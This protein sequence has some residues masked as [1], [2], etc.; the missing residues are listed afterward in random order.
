MDRIAIIG[1]GYIG[2]SIGY[3]LRL[4]HS[5][6]YRVVGFDYDSN[7]QRQ[8]DKTGALDESNWALGDTVR[9]ADI[10]VIATPSAAAKELFA[11]M[12]GDLKPGAIVTDTT[13]TA[14]TITGWAEE[15]L[16]KSVGFVAGHP[17]ISGVGIEEASGAAFDGA[18]WALAPTA[19][20]PQDAVRRTIRLVED[21]GAK[22]FFISVEEHDSYIAA[23]TNLPIIVSNAMMLAAARSP[24][25]REIGKFATDQFGEV[26]SA[27]RLNPATNIGSLTGNAEMTIHWIEQMIIELADFRAMLEDE[28]RDDPDGPL[29]ETLNNAWEARLRWENGIEPGDIQRPE[30][31]TSGD[32]MLGVLVGYKVAERLKGVRDRTEQQ[33][34]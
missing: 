27:S 10:I 11:D 26:S 16:P 25:W 33:N 29:S 12:A 18:R 9:D 3:T 17:L 6:R 32:M 8:A 30:L 34:Y 28:S 19:F 13:T 4:N 22:P 14:G 31:P 21:L 7:A 20:A 24:S 15:Y 5:K 2:A 1:L 23:A